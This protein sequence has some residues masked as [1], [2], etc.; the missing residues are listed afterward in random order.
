[1]MG[2][3]NNSMNGSMNRMGGTSKDA[4]LMAVNQAGFAVTEANLYLDTHP[5]DQAA[6]AYFQ[7]YNQLRCQALNDYAALYGP[8]TIETARGGR[9]KWEWVNRPWPWEGEDC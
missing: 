5:S 3:M 4:L 8:L 9:G 1:M 6:L 2:N 7:E